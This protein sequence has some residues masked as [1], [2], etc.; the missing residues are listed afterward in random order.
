MAG[1]TVA[2]G[3]AAKS[4]ERLKRQGSCEGSGSA[5]ERLGEPGAT[6]MK[7]G[8][9]HGPKPVAC[10][11]TQGGALVASV[12]GRQLVIFEQN[13]P[14]SS[15]ST[16]RLVKRKHTLGLHMQLGQ[17]QRVHGCLHLKTCSF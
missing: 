16:G 10:V 17:P 12:Y 9:S 7:L 2:P 4:W 11:V 5:R 15:E 13:M 1:G 8:Q 14:E 6:H 3:G